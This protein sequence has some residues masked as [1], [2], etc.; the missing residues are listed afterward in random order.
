MK[1]LRLL[2]KKEMTELR[3]EIKSV[4]AK[5]KRAI[6]SARKKSADRGVDD[7]VEQAGYDELD[8]ALDTVFNGL[9][10]DDEK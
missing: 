9:G 7:S 10:L 3:A 1:Q 6:A 4:Q 5:I 8:S 2:L